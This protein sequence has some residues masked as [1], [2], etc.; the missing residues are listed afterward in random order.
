MKKGIRKYVLDSRQSEVEN[1]IPKNITKGH[2]N[3]LRNKLVS[4]LN[5]DLKCS[6]N[7][8]NAEAGA[9]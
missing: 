1:V 7:L 9:L 5:I 4:Q 8:A 6:L 2:L 3:L